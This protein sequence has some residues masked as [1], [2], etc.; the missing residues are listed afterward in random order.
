MYD[1]SNGGINLCGS[2]N[3]IAAMKEP[4]STSVS[5]IQYVL[6]TKLITMIRCCYIHAS[7]S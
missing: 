7:S 4:R 2:V 1:L 3:D 6:C 5:K